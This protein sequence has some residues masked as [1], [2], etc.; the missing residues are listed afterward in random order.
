MRNADCAMPSRTPTKPNLLSLQQAGRY[1]A[2]YNSWQ[3]SAAAEAETLSRLRTYNT[4]TMAPVHCLP[5]SAA[6]L[7]MQ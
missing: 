5:L 2:G 7:I 6:H 3:P 1:V 4:K